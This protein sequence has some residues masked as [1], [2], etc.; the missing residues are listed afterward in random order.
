MGFVGPSTG[1]GGPYPFGGGGVWRVFV[2]CGRSTASLSQCLVSECLVW[3]CLVSQCLGSQY[4]AARYSSLVRQKGV[5][6]NPQN[7]DISVLPRELGPVD[8]V[9]GFI[10]MQTREIQQ[11]R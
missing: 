4:L 5:V 8:F 10:D 3:Q 9:L 7:I 6:F 2:T 1:A 11:L